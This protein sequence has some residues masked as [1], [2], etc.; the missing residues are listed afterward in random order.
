VSFK[1]EFVLALNGL[2]LKLVLISYLLCIKYTVQQIGP[3]VNLKAP[4]LGINEKYLLIVNELLIKR[5]NFLINPNM[6]IQV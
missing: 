6:I 5:I 3:K 2:N 1:V 4:L